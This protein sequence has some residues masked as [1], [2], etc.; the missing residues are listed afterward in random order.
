MTPLFLVSFYIVSWSTE[1]HLGIVDVSIHTLLR[2]SVLCRI[3]L[4]SLDSSSFCPRKKALMSLNLSTDDYD[5][6]RSMCARSSD[7]G[8][9]EDN[10]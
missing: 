7:V 3:L 10:D 8:S 6:E 2:E 5:D 9:F 1:S 4:L